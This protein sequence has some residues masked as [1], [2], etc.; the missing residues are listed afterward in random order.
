MKE[1]TACLY[2]AIA[3][4]IQSVFAT[5][6]CSA[7]AAWKG[8]LIQETFAPQFANLGDGRLNGTF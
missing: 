3:V 1:F 5:E 8:H 4:L 6:M 2:I 7:S